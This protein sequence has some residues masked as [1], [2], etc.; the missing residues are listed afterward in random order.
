M[1]DISCNRRR[2][3]ELWTEGIMVCVYVCVCVG[4]GG[5]VNQQIQSGKYF[6]HN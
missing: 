5:G 3:E 1:Q 4:G 2:Q 6:F